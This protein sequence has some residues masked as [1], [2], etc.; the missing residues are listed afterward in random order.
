WYLLGVIDFFLDQ[1]VFHS[2]RPGR[3]V[4]AEEIADRFD[5]AVGAAVEDKI[6]VMGEDTAVSRYP[7]LDLDDR[8]MSWIP[9]YKLV[10]IIH[11]HFHRTSALQRKKICHRHVHE[12]AFAAEI[13]A[14]V[15]RM[16]QKFFRGDAKRGRHLVAQC[17]R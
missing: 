5:R 11:H 8:S 6:H 14:D 15:A 4:G 10:A 17:K 7:R 16:N 13:A 1:R 2:V 12:V 3:F 9:S